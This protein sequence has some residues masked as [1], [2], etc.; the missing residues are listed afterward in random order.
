MNV[1]CG[2]SEWAETKRGGWMWVAEA[3][4][5]RSLSHVHTHGRAHSWTCTLM[6]VHT[7]TGSPTEL[8]TCAFTAGCG[9]S[10]ISTNSGPGLSWSGASNS[11]DP[12]RGSWRGRLILSI[13]PS[14]VGLRN[15]DDWLCPHSHF[16]SPSLLDH[17]PSHPEKLCRGSIFLLAWPFSPSLSLSLPLSLPEV[18]VTSCAGSL[19]VPEWRTC[20]ILTSCFAIP[21]TR[22]KG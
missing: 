13:L 7:P 22:P 20:S 15:E 16:L 6:D 14:L 9:S 8:C 11:S 18:S 4:S 2:S 17:F 21:H 3:P 12:G 1:S 19:S 10:D 5:S